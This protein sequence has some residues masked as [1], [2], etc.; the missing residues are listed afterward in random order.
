MADQPKLTKR[1][2]EV[3]D[4]ILE[5]I[6]ARGYGPTVREIGQRFD[7]RSPNGVMCHLQAL[8]KKGLISREPGMSRAISI[9]RKEDRNG[10]LPLAG[11]IAAGAPIQAY[12]QA[13]F[14]DLNDL[15]NRT[16]FFALRVSGQSMIEDHIEDGDFVVIRKQESAQDGQ[17]VVA[18]VD[19]AET[20]LKRF[21]RER[22]RYRLEPAN[23]SMQPIY[24]DNVQILGV[25]VGVIR[26]FEPTR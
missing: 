10:A 4:F 17:V 22:G 21:F 2:Q 8:V 26:K 14:L 9:L 3:Y 1:Q 15:F 7:I 19:G 25:L 13:E 5:K 16:D 23:D 11:T 20:T 6:R 18:L 12:E 24:S